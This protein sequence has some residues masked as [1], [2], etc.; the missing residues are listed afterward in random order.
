VPADCTLTTPNNNN[1]VTGCPGTETPLTIIVTCNPDCQT[2]I[3]EVVKDVPGIEVIIPDSPACDGAPHNVEIVF[4]IAA[5]AEPG[6]RDFHI[7]GR[8]VDANGETQ[9]NCQIALRVVVCGDD[10][11]AAPVCCAH[12]NE[13][14]FCCPKGSKSCCD[15]ECCRGI[16]CDGECCVEDVETCCDVGCCPPMHRSCCEDECCAGGIRL[17]SDS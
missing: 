7:Y 10:P 2:L 8:V 5:D 15:G 14:P 9:A 16:C 1:T 6:P 11:D 13:P 4:Q 3:L 17:P 12:E